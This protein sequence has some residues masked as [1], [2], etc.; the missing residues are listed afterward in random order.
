MFHEVSKRGVSTLNTLDQ[1]LRNFLLKSGLV[2]YLDN[3]KDSYYNNDDVIAGIINKHYWNYLRKNCQIPDP[4]EIINECLQS[5]D[6]R[7]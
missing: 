4:S 5:P 1:D 6:W 3:F 7:G 2:D